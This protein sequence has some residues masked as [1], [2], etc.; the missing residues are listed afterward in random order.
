[1]GLY[2]HGVSLSCSIP[3]VNNAPHNTFD[4]NI[5]NRKDTRGRWRISPSREASCV[6]RP[7]EARDM[8]KRRD[9]DRLGSHFVPHVPPVSLVSPVPLARTDRLC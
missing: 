8:R 5:S 3:A 4:P 6:D 7:R 9:V 1:M 2:S